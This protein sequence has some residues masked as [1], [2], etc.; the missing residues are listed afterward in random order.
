MVGQAMT[1]APGARPNR[2]PQ[3]LLVD[4]DATVRDSM[5]WLLELH[6]HPV[7]TAANGAEALDRLRNGLRPRVILLDLIMPVMDG[8]EFREKQIQD[9]ELAAIPVLVYSGDFDS[10]AN[11]KRLG[12]TAYFQKAAGVEALLKLIEKLCL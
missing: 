7:V 1:A 11:A 8:F 6:G 2:R 5:K 9:A 4:D 3:V 12:A 10:A